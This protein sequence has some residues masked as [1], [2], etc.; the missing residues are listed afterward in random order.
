MSFDFNQ[1]DMDAEFFVNEDDEAAAADFESDDANDHDVLDD[2]A[3]HFDE[4]DN[5]LHDAQKF[6]DIRVK[7]WQKRSHSKIPKV[8]FDAARRQVW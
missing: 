3:D 1:W 4:F 8:T 6:T 2:D 5:I 7:D